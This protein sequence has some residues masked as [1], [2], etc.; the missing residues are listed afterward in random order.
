MKKFVF[1][2]IL[3]CSLTF[4]TQAN[5]IDYEKPDI[6]AI[7]TYD[8]CI[9]QV[10]IITE[11]V[12]NYQDHQGLHVFQIAGS[13]YSAGNTASGFS[14]DITID[15]GTVRSTNT[16]KEQSS[17]SQFTES[18]ELYRGNLRMFGA[19]SCSA[20]LQGDHYNTKGDHY[21]PKRDYYL[22]GDPN[23]L[24]SKDILLVR[25]WTGS[26]FSRHYSN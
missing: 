8:E 2:L 20:N 23:E 14:Q 6:T 25:R 4:T 22:T 11:A 18:W 13:R 3:I 12:G 24:F 9:M 5:T 26:D 7:D 16:N 21:R 17:Y 15:P 10:Q 1:G 19:E